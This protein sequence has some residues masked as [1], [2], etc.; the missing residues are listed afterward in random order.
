MQDLQYDPG[1]EYNSIR[2]SIYMTK[3]EIR[4]FLVSRNKLEI[5]FIYLR[6]NRDA[7]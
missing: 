4:L 2:N 7:L 3:L 6:E 1:T 5:K